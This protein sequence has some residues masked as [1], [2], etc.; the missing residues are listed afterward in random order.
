MQQNNQQVHC[1]VLYS[2]R[3]MFCHSLLWLGWWC[4]T[5][6]LLLLLLL[7][8]QH[9][10]IVTSTITIVETGRTFESKPDHHVGQKFLQEYMGR[11]QLLKENESLC[12]PQ[13]Q[14][15]HQPSS[16]SSSPSSP[17]SSSL[18]VGTVMNSFNNNNNNNNNN[19][20]N[21]NSKLY[22]IT[23]TNDGLPVA[24]IVTGGGGCSVADKA[25]VATTMIAPSGV[26][27]YLII[28][29]HSKRLTKGSGPGVED[30]NDDN[31]EIL[32]VVALSSDDESF[33]FHTSLN[34]TEETLPFPS[35]LLLETVDDESYLGRFPMRVNE[36]QQQQQQ[37]PSVAILHVSNKVGNLLVNIID[38]EI[39]LV[40]QSGGTKVFL[41]GEGP[42][43]GK[44]VF[45][46][47][48]A[49]LF[50]CACGCCCMLMAVQTAWEDEQQQQQQ[51]N[52]TPPVRRRL[53]LQQVRTRFP[54]FHFN[55]AE[56]Q[57]QANH[58]DPAQQ[59]CQLLDECTICLDE[60]HVGVRCRQ[61]PCQH[62]FHSTCIARW[63]IERSAVC[64]LC[65]MDLFEDEEAQDNNEEEEEGNQRDQNVTEESEPLFSR[66]WWTNLTN[67]S[68][69]RTAPSSGVQVEIPPQPQ[70][71]DIPASSMAPTTTDNNDLFVTRNWWPLSVEVAPLSSV[72][73]DHR[74]SNG[75][76]PTRPS[77]WRWNL[78]GRLRRS[79]VAGDWLVTELTEPLIAEETTT[80]TM[81]E[82]QQQQQQELQSFLQSRQSMEVISFSRTT[83]SSEDDTNE[84]LTGMDQPTAATEIV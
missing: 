16:S 36:Q 69:R 41:T 43:R 78:F 34:H 65:K 28:K 2:K 27:K 66:Q 57:Q 62:V 55:P 79:E 64:P 70:S 58:K 18:V 31:D 49:V 63:L 46:W 37:Q 44:M 8:L 76:P 26:V 11:I 75:R 25:M 21:I 6:Q 82:S 50:M 30:D 19:I 68:G 17:S 40:R 3:K 83:T 7:L 80:M 14:Q 38:T 74:S 1:T 72:E 5:V 84:T 51:Q 23:P 9:P 20:N 60:F 32:P 54:A 77:P 22:K 59:Y 81:T 47:M 39:D 67:H 71:P 45:T 56:H 4:V 53:T 35:S 61:L 42:D 73:E 24:L 12:P 29:D 52:A 10:Q 48:L 13:L 33:A 15:Q